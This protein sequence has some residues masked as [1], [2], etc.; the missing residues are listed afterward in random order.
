MRGFKTSMF[1]VLSRRA[2]NATTSKIEDSVNH[3]EP[4]QVIFDFEKF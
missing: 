2:S 1:Q 4:K 3:V